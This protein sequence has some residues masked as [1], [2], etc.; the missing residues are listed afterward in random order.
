MVREAGAESGRLPPPQPTTSVNIRA[1]A[2][3]PTHRLETVFMITTIPVAVKV[4]G[5]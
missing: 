4:L 3:S 1:A 5:S 2:T